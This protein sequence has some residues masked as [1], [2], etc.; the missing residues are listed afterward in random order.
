[1]GRYLNTRDLAKRQSELQDELKGQE[2]LLADLEE[3]VSE[4]DNADE[5]MESIQLAREDLENWK[6]EYQDELDE[7]D[8]LESEIGGDWNYGETLIPED[9][10][11]DYAMELADDIGVMDKHASWPFN[12]IDWEAAAKELEMD[13]TQVEFQGETYLVRAG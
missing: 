11:V 3:E 5:L 10:F 13:Y 12:H 8:R 4:D 9:D 2:L 1:M 7:L 6:V